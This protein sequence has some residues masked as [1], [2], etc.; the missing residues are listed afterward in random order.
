MQ[1]PH[2]DKLHCRNCQKE[3]SFRTEMKSGQNTAYCNE[4]GKYLKNVPYEKDKYFY[5]GKYSGIC[6]SQIEDLS[7]LRWA[8][9]NMK[10]SPAYKE[11]VK[12]QI[13]KLQKRSLEDT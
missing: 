5:V 3:V 10:L 1:P 4:C 13:D 2:I 9:D 6:I 8:F 7:Y 11:A 12:N